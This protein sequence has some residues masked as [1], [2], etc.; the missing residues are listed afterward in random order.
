MTVTPTTGCGS[1]ADSYP[2]DNHFAFHLTSDGAGSIWFDFRA[3]G[4]PPGGKKNQRFQS[5]PVLVQQV[6]WDDPLDKPNSNFTLVI[7]QPCLFTDT[8]TGPSG[9]VYI[10]IGDIR[11]EKWT[12]P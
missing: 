4:D 5:D 8:Q 1:G 7:R 12:T 6:V 11:F 3:S 2:L 10:S 9:P